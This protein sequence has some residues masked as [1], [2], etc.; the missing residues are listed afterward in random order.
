[1]WRH[2][3]LLGRYVRSTRRDH[4][5][6]GADTETERRVVWYRS[7]LSLCQRMLLQLR[8]ATLLERHVP[9]RFSHDVYH[10]FPVMELL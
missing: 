5:Y 8:C 7:E 1:V 9:R 6:A 10:V 2:P 4:P 3:G